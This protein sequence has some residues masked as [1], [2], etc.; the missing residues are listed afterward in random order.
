MNSSLAISDFLAHRERLRATMIVH[1]ATFD[2]RK[3]ENQKNIV[4]RLCASARCRFIVCLPQHRDGTVPS[5]VRHIAPTSELRHAARNIASQGT[6]WGVGLVVVASC[7]SRVKGENLSASTCF[8]PYPHS[9]R[10][11]GSEFGCQAVIQAREPEPRTCATNV[12]TTDGCHS[13]RQARSKHSRIHPACI[14]QDMAAR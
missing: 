2:S 7:L 8:P 1:L 3:H 11:N 10:Q 4:V 5:E 6:V 14:H 12:P 9:E 13:L